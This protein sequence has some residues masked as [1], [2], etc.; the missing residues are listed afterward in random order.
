MAARNIN[1]LIKAVIENSP[2]APIRIEY[3][4]DEFRLTKIPLLE[5]S[6]AEEL[7]FRYWRREG[8]RNLSLKKILRYWLWLLI[9]G[10]AK[11]QYLARLTAW[12]YVISFLERYSDF[13]DFRMDDK[14]SEYETLIINWRSYDHY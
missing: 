6:L 7:E 11:D 14:T 8:I 1:E 3:R 5:F 12:A 4:K 2:T 9:P 13:L 10:K